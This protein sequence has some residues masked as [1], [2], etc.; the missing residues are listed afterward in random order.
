[1]TDKE[2]K[3]LLICNLKQK[4]Q[5]KNLP[6]IEDVEIVYNNNN[7]YVLKTA[8]PICYEVNGLKYFK[9]MF[10]ILTYI[11]LGEMANIFFVAE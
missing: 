9:N 6:K 2:V 8:E 10:C 3:K 7:F 1:M 4:L 11:I 5:A